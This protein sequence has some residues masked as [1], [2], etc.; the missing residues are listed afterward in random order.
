M[1]QSQYLNDRIEQDHRRIKR[2][3]HSMLGCKST[4]CAANILDGIEM[5][6]MMP[7]R[8]A[9]DAYNPTIRDSRCVTRS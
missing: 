4:T 1:L 6:H 7:K 5:I 9:R 3:V 2:R 8:Q